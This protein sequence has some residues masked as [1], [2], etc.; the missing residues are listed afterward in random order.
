MALANGGFLHYTDRKKFLK[1]LF[2]H[3]WSDFKIVSQKCS[4]SDLSQK[5]NMALVKG[6]LLSLYGHEK[7]HKK[8][9]FSETAGQILK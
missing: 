2:R 7:I 9:F 5:L 8:I 3:R 4:L 1:S 6:G